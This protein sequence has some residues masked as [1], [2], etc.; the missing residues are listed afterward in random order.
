MGMLSSHN[1][2]TPEAKCSLLTPLSYQ[3]HPAPKVAFAIFS[4]GESSMSSTSKV[5]AF[6]AS[7]WFKSRV[8]SLSVTFSTLA[9]MP[10]D[11]WT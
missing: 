6:P 7:S 10:L 2:D 5:R 4:A 1:D 3:K 8:T 9:T 11:S